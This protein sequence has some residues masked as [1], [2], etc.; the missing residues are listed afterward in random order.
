M[1]VAVEIEAVI[2]KY[3]TAETTENI[4][5]MEVLTFKMPAYE[6]ILIHSGVG[7]LGAAAACQLLIT[8]YGCEMVVNF[9]VVGGLTEEMTLAKTCI[10]DKVVHYDFDLSG[11]DPVQ[12]AQYPE[13]KDEYIP[14]DRKLFEMVRTLRPDL[15]SVI[16]ASADKFISSA[17]TKKQLHERYHA[18]ICEMEAAG[19]ALTCFRNNIPC[20]MIKCVSDAI[21]GGAEEYMKEVLNSSKVCLDVLDEILEKL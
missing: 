11:I 13:L 6:L 10:V 18:D 3:G 19:I 16:C 4:G 2:S 17:E 8:Y 5:N 1:I 15:K 7:E 14:S 21:S 20:L 12:P 9:G